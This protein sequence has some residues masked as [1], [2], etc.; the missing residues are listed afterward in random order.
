MM[1]SLF[2]LLLKFKVAY[3]VLLTS[4]LKFDHKIYS[5]K[6]VPLVKDMIISKLSMK[7]NKKLEVVWMKLEA[8]PNES[9]ENICE[10]D[11]GALIDLKL[12]NT[13]VK[14][15]F[16]KQKDIGFQTQIYKK[17][18]LANIHRFQFPVGITKKDIDKFFTHVH[19][20]PELLK[21]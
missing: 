6:E 18:S 17:L 9:I 8:S 7:D 4:E 11:H 10:Y 5:M 19:Y 3:G 20:E 16:S 1:I 12:E 13:K 14:A 2:T 21:K 15:C